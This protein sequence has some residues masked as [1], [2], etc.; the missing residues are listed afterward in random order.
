M[1]GNLIVSNV[2]NHGGGVD[3]QSSNLVFVNNVIANN[4]AAA[5]GRGVQL[6]YGH[7]E[8]K[9]SIFWNNHG[10]EIDAD[11]E[12]VDVSYCD[13]EG[14]YP[15]VGNIDTDPLFRDTTSGDYHLMSTVC[16][17]PFDS[18]CIDAGSP[19]FWDELVDCDHGLGSQASDIGAYGGGFKPCSYVVGD[20][21]DNGSA[22]GVDVVYLVNYFKLGIAPG[23]ICD[24]PEAD[25]FYAPADVNGSCEANGV[26]VIYYVNFL[27]GYGPGLTF[28]P[29]CPPIL[30]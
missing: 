2:N 11:P 8:I 1:T 4:S 27:K 9:N 19:E 15:G 3:I 22:D 23:Y 17:D 18:P 25:D 13:V 30:K 24:C 10:S 14:G 5:G 7:A 12:S 28:C 29:E 20:A 16:G 6:R 21:N 26:D